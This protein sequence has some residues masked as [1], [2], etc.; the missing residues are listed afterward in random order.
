MVLARLRV[1]GAWL[2]AAL[3]A[4]HPVQVQSVAWVTELKNTQSCL[5]WLLAI[6]FFLKWRESR[7][8]ADRRHGWTL[9]A[10]A[11]L[12]AA[13]AI[14]SKSST[15]MLPV[16]FGLCWSWD[17]GRWRW[18]NAA[19][20]AP[21]FVIS[22]VASGWT[23]WEQKFHAGAIGGDWAQTWPQRLII[24]GRDVWF[25]LGKLAWPHPLIFIYPRWRIDASQP[26]AYLPVFAAV[27]AMLVLWRRRNDWGRPFF[28]AFAY[29]VVSLFPVLGFFNVYYFRFSFV[30]DHFQYLASMGP[31]ALAAAGMTR[32]PAILGPSS[33]PSLKS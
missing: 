19:P 13:A 30:A 3:W 26:L 18:R 14:L 33:V 27:I 31:L 29:F 6:L 25:Y 17:E 1:P 22:A 10:L 21:F 16:V 28:F 5:F 12:G 11:L 23:I 8:L 32:I 7:A 2:G 20:L 15:V 24:A 4:L 9:Y